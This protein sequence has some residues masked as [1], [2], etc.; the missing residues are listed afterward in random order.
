MYFGSRHASIPTPHDQALAFGLC[1]VDIEGVMTISVAVRK[2][3]RHPLFQVSS[4]SAS[5]CALRK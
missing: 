4:V 1:V 2:G 3:L 5:T